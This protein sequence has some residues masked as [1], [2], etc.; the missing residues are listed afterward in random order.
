MK[1][2]LASLLATLALMSGVHANES[3]VLDKFP[4][5]R[6]TDL[7]ALQNG[8]KLFVNYCLNCHAAAFMRFNRLKDIGLTEQ[9]IKD[10]MLFPT[11]KVGEVMKVSLD[12]K[13]A[14][15][16]FGA[17]PPDL[18][19]VA[20]SRSS[21]AGSGGDVVSRAVAE[22]IRKE[23]FLPQALMVNNRVGG[24]G[25]VGWSFFKT[26][27]GDPYYMMSVTGTILS[28]AYRPETQI[29]LENYTPLALFAI[30]PQT[31]MVPMDSPFKTVKDL[32]DAARAKPDSLVAATTSL[33][34]TGRL[35]V[36]LLEKAVPSAK[37]K[38]VT[39]KGG[40]EA[41]TSTAGGHTAFTTENLGEGQGFVEGK[42]LRVLALSSDKRLPQAPD[43]PTLMEL[44]YPITAGTIRGFTFTAGVPREAVVTME[45]ALKK[46]HDA[47]EWK[48]LAR[49]NLYQDVFMG[50]AEFTKFLAARM[51]EY[52]EF[53]DA[54]GLNKR[55]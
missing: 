7:A 34:G 35:V 26:K 30:D 24:A 31:I 48:E 23:K 50:S 17:A 52:K 43:V 27:R 37:F 40:G 38:I 33:Q 15:E 20:R 21:P 22:I 29:G 11:D 41:V 28:I 18:T 54:I 49:R 5:E 46:A 10:N 8:A 25:I 16:W 12:P 14:K 36:H 45:T 32:M 51:V 6:V 44:G 19:V 3:L 4:K 2:L 42:K 13:D 55:Q 47:P 9:Q 53:Y 1:K 39:F